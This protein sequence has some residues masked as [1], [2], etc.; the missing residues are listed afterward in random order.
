M[1]SEL[2]LELSTGCYVELH[3]I[4]LRDH[5]NCLTGHLLV[6]R[7]VT[8]RQQADLELRQVNERLQAQ[9]REIKVLQTQLREQAIRDAL[10]GLCNRRYFEE[11]LPRELARAARAAY[12][13]AVI[14]MDIDFFKQVNDTY[15]HQG[16]D[17]VLQAVSR[18]LRAHSRQGDIA[19]RYGGEEFVLL[20]PAITLKDVCQRAEQLRRSFQAMRVPFGAATI[21]TTLSLGVGLFPEHGDTSQSLMQVVDQALYVAKAAG[22]NCVKCVETVV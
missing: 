8:Q 1:P 22:R 14:L 12:P 15:G 10:T 19:C 18:L 20:L 7:N 17:C 5:C 2:L 16:G 13:V 4:P 3:V 11:T 9:L 6:L 21:R